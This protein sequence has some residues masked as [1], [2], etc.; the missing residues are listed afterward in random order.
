MNLHQKNANKPNLN[1]K[2][3]H[4]LPLIRLVYLGAAVLCIG[5]ATRTEAQTNPT[6][7]QISGSGPNV[8]LNWNSAAT[9]QYAPSVGGPWTTYSGGVSVLSTSSLAASGAA[10]FFRTVLNG[11]AGPPVSLL[12][13]TLPA[14]LQVESASL[15]LLSSPVPA[16]NTRLVLTL[17]PGSVSSSNIITLLLNNGLTELRDD[18]QF[19]DQVAGDGNF[20]AVINLNPSDIDSWNAE[21]ANLPPD[22]QI[23]YLFS[24]RAI[25][26][27][28][29]LQP[30]PK[31]NFLAGQTV[32]FITNL[33]ATPP[34][35]FNPCAGSP[36]AYNPFKTEMIIDLSVVADT[37]RTWDN[38]GPPLPLGPSPPGVGNRTGAWTFNTLMT[39]MANTLATGI[40]PSDFVLRWLQ[41]YQVPQTIN[42]DNVPPVA[43]VQSLILTPWQQAT[44]AEG[45]FPTNAVDLSIAPFRL[46]AIVNRLDLR[47]NSTYGPS[48]N[49][50]ASPEFAGEARFVFCAINPA[51]GAP[52]NFTVILE[53]A[54]PI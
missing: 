16:G 10:Q 6:T 17:A 4:R 20:S 49:S 1:W 19:P 18:G 30:F 2:I 39:A 40:T 36:T 53:Y 13:S 25:V 46:L 43:N 3:P 48:T 32:T 11:V 26:A 54:V 37:N 38:N 29:S 35:P 44:A 24:E 28:N 21:L 7:L 52:L 41:S 34:I 47:A 22:S 12:P 50:G 14:P 31:A 27:T 51:N 42:L 8:N 15:Q 45:G 33:V 9:L 5:S 23:S